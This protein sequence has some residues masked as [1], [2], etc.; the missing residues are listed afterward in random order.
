[1]CQLLSVQI[2]P[3]HCVGHPSGCVSCHLGCP[4][5]ARGSKRGGVWG[6]VNIVV[7]V[8][9]SINNTVLYICI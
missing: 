6:G 7:V 2:T 4:C 8:V 5:I 1:M 9:Y 3:E